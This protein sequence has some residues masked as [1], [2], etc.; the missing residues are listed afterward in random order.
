MKIVIP[1]DVT[2]TYTGSAEV[3]RLR[4]TG[5]VEIHTTRAANEDEL[6]QRIG[7]AD[8]VVSFRPA[9]TRFPAGVIRRCPSLRLICISGTG[10]EDVDVTE[11]TARGIAV[12]NVVGSADQ[13]VAE[14]AIALMFDVAR[15]VSAQDRAIRDGAW[16]AQEGI[17]LG[18]KTLGIVGLSAIGS[19][20]ARIGNALGMRVL[21]W[22]RNNDP[23]RAR[24]VGATAASL[25]EVLAQADF[26][27]LHLRL[28]PELR[29]F[30]DQAKFARMKPGAILINTARG[31]LVDDTAL[32]AALS[33]GRLR[34]A[35]LDVF[36]QQPLPPEHPLRGLAN[37]VMTPSAGWNT[38]DASYRMIVQSIDNVLGFIAGRPIN[39]VNAAALSRPAQGETP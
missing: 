33:S 39:I 7:D 22:S 32:V 17:E 20:V 15:H 13:A 35:G 12:A 37:V 29:G 23:A 14:L 4:A 26:L 8:I 21:S 2:R 16:Q 10:V 5:T 19:V 6:A 3:D 9:F 18:G 27:S 25:D 36:S 11:A 34:G 1:D 28:F 38:A 31:E 30:L 24:A